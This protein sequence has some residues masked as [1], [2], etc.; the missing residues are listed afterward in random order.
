MLTAKTSLMRFVLGAAIAATGVPAIAA[1]HQDAAAQA[2]SPATPA[3]SKAS[4]KPD[5]GV[6]V[7]YGTGF[8]QTATVRLNG[9]ELTGA[10]KFKADK[11]KLRI[12][13]PAA[14]AQMKTKGQ[15]RLEILQGASASGAFEF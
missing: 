9:V 14:A 3:I 11:N 10:K 12:S 2:P 7:V 1:T 13:L 15:N 6:L 5:K 4:Y 8:D